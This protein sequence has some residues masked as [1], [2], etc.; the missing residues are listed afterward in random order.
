MNCSWQ[1]SSHVVLL[2][3][4]GNVRLHLSPTE[5][6]QSGTCRLQ[7]H[8]GQ[9]R[10]LFPLPCQVLPLYSSYFPER[11][12][13]LL[14]FPIRKS[15]SFCFLLTASCQGKSEQIMLCGRKIKREKALINVKIF[16]GKEKVW[17]SRWKLSICQSQHGLFL[18]STILLW[19]GILSQLAGYRFLW[20]GWFLIVTLN[21]IQDLARTLSVSS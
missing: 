11:C 1:D 9:Q 10:W 12:A 6:R 13:I 8:Q 21:Q 18:S 15:F 7:E 3:I 4:G 16:Q 17:D 14:T 2:I 5:I 20:W 19:S